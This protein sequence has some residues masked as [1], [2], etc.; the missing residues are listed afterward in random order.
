M[1]DVSAD[2][3][4]EPKGEQS[5]VVSC[6]LTA[7]VQP[8]SAWQGLTTFHPPLSG[9]PGL[10]SPVFRWGK[11]GTV[12]GH[13]SLKVTRRISGRAGSRSVCME[14]ACVWKGTTVHK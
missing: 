3:C 7:E 13:D 6:L 2:L 14:Q 5:S 10:F 8:Q 11:G 12:Q 9:L 1:G 4:P